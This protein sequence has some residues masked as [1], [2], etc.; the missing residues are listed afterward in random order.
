MMNIIKNLR[1]RIIKPIIEA[2][3]GEDLIV[4]G[5]NYKEELYAAL[6]EM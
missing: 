1:N 2:C 5:K 3:T 6:D 4:E